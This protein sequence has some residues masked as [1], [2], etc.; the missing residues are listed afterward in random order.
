MT[1]A[2]EH[3]PTPSSFTSVIYCCHVGQLTPKCLSRAAHG[4]A[5]ADVGL[6]GTVW[7]QC[8]APT[9]DKNVIKKK[10]NLHE[11]RE[12]RVKLCIQLHHFS[13]NPQEGMLC[14]SGQRAKAYTSH[15]TYSKRTISWTETGS[16][17]SL[18]SGNSVRRRSG[19]EPLL[20]GLCVAVSSSLWCHLWFSVSNRDR[21]LT[22]RTRLTCL[23]FS[24]TYWIAAYFFFWKSKAVAYLTELNALFRGVGHDCTLCYNRL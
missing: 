14:I 1:P 24:M 13:Q 3:I 21:L 15:Q 22:A 23:F 8:I 20:L 17:Q 19:A 4:A 9:G 10:G 12:Q 5:S 2:R 11:A 16:T 18:Q 6:T 7:A